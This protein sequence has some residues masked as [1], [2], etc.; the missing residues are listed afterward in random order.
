MASVDQ[1]L[2]AKG[3]RTLASKVFKEFKGVYTK[4]DRSAIP[5]DHFYNLENL[6]PIGSS[7]IH[8]VNGASASLLNYAADI[9]YWSQYVQVGITAYQI[10]IA[11]SG[12]VFA[13]NWSTLTSAQINSGNLLSGIG[14]RVTQ[15]M[16]LYALF[17]DSTGI[18]YWDGST[19]ANITGTGVPTTATDIVTAMGRVWVASG[20]LL[21][22]TA[23]YDATSTTDPKN[24]TAWQTA[25]G[26]AFANFTDP[27]LV[28]N[29]TRL[30]A[31]NGFLFVAGSTCLW[32]VTNVYV[33]AGASPPT[34]VM[35][36][37]N[38]QAIN[39]TDQPA[40]MVPYGNHMVFAN[41]Y[42]AWV[43]DGQSAEQLSEDI[44]GTW[45][46][47]A[48]SPSISAG[49]CVV[50]NKLCAAFLMQRANDPNFGSNCV[51][52]MYFDK[53]WW[54]ANFGT[55]TFLSTAIINSV[56]TL[57]AFIGNQMY[58]LFT[59]TT[60]F[61]NGIAQTPLWDMDDPL[62]AKEVIRAGVRV[63]LFS[64]AGSINYTVDGLVSSTQV[65]SQAGA[66][67]TFT[68]LGGSI[69]TFVGS[70]PILWTSLG[71][72][73]LINGVSPGVFSTNVGMTINTFN[74]NIQL[75]L[76]AMDY[77]KG[78]RWSAQ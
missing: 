56:P 11:T 15:F 1:Q 31:Q 55:I 70:G 22:C 78:Q 8:S 17:A 51:I 59:N 2:P 25:N 18:Y 33:P 63:V 23:A 34:P 41:R 60:T 62:S 43:T 7:N 44:D 5:E 53:K 12:K 29:I 76:I 35:T 13:F 49:E 57:V 65:T 9:I 19:F 45:Q 77:K 21:Q 38:I 30:T 37:Y 73:E 3:E 50:N 14:S 40:S 68:G 16:N 52:G 75:C 54:F 58:T 36:I 4:S 28:G 67:I 72:Y 26:S 27:T 71:S 69:I 47:L 61:P 64:G 10:N 46:Y 24:A 48:F 66:N 20:R 74:E 6:M 32:G 39:G 42:G